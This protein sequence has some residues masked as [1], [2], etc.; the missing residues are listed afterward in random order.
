MMSKMIIE[1]GQYASISYSKSGDE[2]HSFK[3]RLPE[4]TVA[5]TQ[6]APSD[7][8]RVTGPSDHKTPYLLCC[9]VE[10]IELDAR[11]EMH[12]RNRRFLVGAGRVR[13][14]PTDGLSVMRP[15]HQRVWGG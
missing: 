5:T 7:A 3:N 1:V 11:L 12:C 15:K 10:I 13:L 4:N 14:Q 2:E 9:W 8:D 6:P